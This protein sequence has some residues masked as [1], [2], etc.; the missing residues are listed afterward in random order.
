MIKEIVWVLHF[1]RLNMKM[2]KILVMSYQHQSS[3]TSFKTMRRMDH[4]QVIESD[5]EV[6]LL[7][8]WL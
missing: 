3:C 8:V 2:W 1:S 7:G 6:L 5:L 4:I